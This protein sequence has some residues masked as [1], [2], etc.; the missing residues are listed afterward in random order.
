[1]DKVRTPQ[2]CARAL[3]AEQELSST[4]GRILKITI[5]DPVITS[6]AARGWSN[7]IETVLF[8]KP[9]EPRSFT[10]VLQAGAN[11][12][13]E[14]EKLTKVVVGNGKLTVKEH[15]PAELGHTG[16]HTKDPAELIDP[17]TL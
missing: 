15:N 12:K 13:K 3:K 8:A 6:E 5:P 4:Q 9:M 17:Y 11:V 16:G 14:I 7:S 2:S 1:M 10:V